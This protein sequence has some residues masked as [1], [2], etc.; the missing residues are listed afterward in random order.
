LTDKLTGSEQVEK[1]FIYISNLTRECRK[2][3]TLKFEREYKGTP[4]DSIEALVKKE[5]ESWF[6]MRDKNIK[7]SY[8]NTMIEKHGE[9]RIT[10][11]GSTKDA[12]F[13]IHI[14][15]LFT[16]VNTAGN[17]ASY[18]KNL[19]LTIDKREFTK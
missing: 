1:A 11:L 3:L 19:N 15:C 8:V 16:V 14:N 17:T 2:V 13:K 9:L 4:F 18:L 5:T 12:H 6:T 10:Y 7:L